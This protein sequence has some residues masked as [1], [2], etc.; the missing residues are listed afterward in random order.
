MPFSHK[1]TDEDVEPTLSYEEIL[2]GKK[3]VK[4]NGVETSV[5]VVSKTIKEIVKHRPDVIEGDFMLF[6][7]LSLHGGGDNRGF[8]TRF[9]LEIRLEIVE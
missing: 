9:S 1:W 3:T 7:P 8:E 4:E 2:Q 5:P 6:S